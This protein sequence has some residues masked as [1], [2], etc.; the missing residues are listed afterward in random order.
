MDKATS[1]ER[2]ENIIQTLG[3]THMGIGNKLE[4]LINLSGRN[5]N[6]IAEATGIAPS[7]L[8]SIIR[9]DNNKVDLDMLQKIADELC[10]TLEYFSTIKNIKNYTCEEIDIMQKYRSLDEHGKR[11]VNIVMNEEL[12]RMSQ[13][14]SYF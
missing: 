12:L 11:I 7:T 13:V 4:Y 9:R 6:D 1:R 2:K 5:V 14:T 10:V 3:R 8:Y